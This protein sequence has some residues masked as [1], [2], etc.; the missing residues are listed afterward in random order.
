VLKLEST[1]VP[2]LGLMKTKMDRC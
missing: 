2:L 1:E